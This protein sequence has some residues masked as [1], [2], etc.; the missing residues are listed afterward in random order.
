MDTG[1]TIRLLRSVSEFQ[2]C[3][4]VQQQAWKFPDLLVI[5]YTQLVTIQHNGGVVLGAFDGD[6]LAGFVFGCLGCQANEP[7]YLYSQRMGVLPAYQGRGIGEALKWAQRTWTVEQGL[8][9]ILWTD[10]HLLPQSAAPDLTRAEPVLL[11]EVP[12]RWQ[13]FR[14]G[15]T[16]LPGDWRDKTRLMFEH[17]MRQGYAVTSYAGGQVAGHWCNFYLLEKQH[18]S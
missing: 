8:T 14:Q 3:Q 5:P 13:E 1:I 9:R 4:Q 17:H 7:L 11:A 10:E 16:A 6:L 15:D 12:A 18:E 2:A